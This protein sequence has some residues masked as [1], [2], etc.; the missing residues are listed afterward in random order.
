MPPPTRAKQIAEVEKYLTRLL[1]SE[2][3]TVGEAAAE[4]VEGFHSLLSVGIKAGVPPLH[5]GLAFKSPLTTHVHHVAWTDGEKVW[6]V[7]A[8]S[9]YGFF[10]PVDHPLWEYVEYTTAKT[11][12][13]GNNPDWKVGDR[14]SR[15][16]RRFKYEV[17]ATGDKCVLLRDE[18]SGVLT[19][20]N[21]ENMKK[22]YKKE[23]EDLWST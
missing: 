5:E 8:G 16:Q 9:R 19:A 21:N 12:A 22:H 6:I 11:G 10:G 7:T 17:I 18:E 2:D 4:I 3:M 20:D 1:D 15:N 14:I 13:P 23:R